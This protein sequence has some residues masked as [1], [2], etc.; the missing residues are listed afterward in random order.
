MLQLFNTVAVIYHGNLIS[1]TTMADA[2]LAAHT[3]PRQLTVSPL[4][5]VSSGSSSLTLSGHS[6]SS[7]DCTIV[8]RGR[9]R[10]LH[11]GGANG[12]GH[13]KGGC[14][15]CQQQTAAAAGAAACDLEVVGCEISTD[16]FGGGVLW[17]EVA[18]GAYISEAR[19]VLVVDDPELAQV[20]YVCHFVVTRLNT[21]Y[22]QM[23]VCRCPAVTATFACFKAA[24]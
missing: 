11:L 20:R 18:R 12:F 23:A 3:L 2:D 10:H 8:V 6:I 14:G 22:C 24:L 19:P 1:L 15:C 4:C 5:L 21:W 13:S 16:G 9:G 17:V 7:P